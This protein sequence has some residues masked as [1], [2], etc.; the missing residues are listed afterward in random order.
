MPALLRQA[1]ASPE[2]RPSRRTDSCADHDIRPERGGVQ[3][4]AEL[5]AGRV[6]P[7]PSLHRSRGRAQRH[8]RIQRPDLPRHRRL[9]LH[10][11]LHAGDS[12]RQSRRRLLVQ[13]RAGRRLRRPP[14]PRRGIADAQDERHLPRH[15]HAG[16]FGDR[17]PSRAELDGAD[18]RPDGH[19]RHPDALLPRHD[20]QEHPAFLLYFPRR[21]RP[22]P[23]RHGEGHREPRG[24]RVDG[25]P[26]GSARRAVSRRRGEPLQSAR[27][28]V[29][30]VLGGRGGRDLRLLHP[31]HRLDLLHA[32]RGLE[33]SLHGHH[34]RAGQPGGADSRLR[35]REFPDRGAPRLRPVAHGRLRAP[36]HHHDVGAAPGS[37]LAQR[38]IKLFA[39]FS[40]GKRT[41]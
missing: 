29:L 18:R 30:R 6:L 10:R 3:T 34:R 11:L 23:L 38:R 41:A 8:Q 12:R 14:R 16:L 1:Q 25:Y 36:D 15:R 2:H 21:L 7:H 26:G 32:G 27:L 28:H 22:L 4:Q 35:P 19:Q 37:C 17:A 40:R 31:L 13:S 9:L 5:P 33:H 20:A 39:R 24:A